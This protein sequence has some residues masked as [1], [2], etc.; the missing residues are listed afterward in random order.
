MYKDKDKQREANRK[1]KAKQRAKQGMT[2]EGMTQQGMTGIV[3]GYPDPVFTSLMAKAKPGLRRVSK[4]DD[5]D[6]VPMCETTMEWK[7]GSPLEPG[8]E[9]SLNGTKM[10]VGAVSEST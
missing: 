7:S 6:Y 8:Q 10:K 2:S 4:P 1:A 5:K 3:E 9:I